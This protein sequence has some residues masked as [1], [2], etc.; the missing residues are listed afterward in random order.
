VTWYRPKPPEPAYGTV[1]EIPAPVGVPAMDLPVEEEAKIYT[2]YVNGDPICVAEWI[3]TEGGFWVFGND[4][5]GKEP[6][7][8]I[9]APRPGDEVHPEPGGDI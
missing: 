1:E 8:M 4:T 9:Y 3:D 7:V 2:W 6:L 5:E